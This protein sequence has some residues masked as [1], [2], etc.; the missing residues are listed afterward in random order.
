[1]PSTGASLTGAAICSSNSL[2]RRLAWS[3][4]IARPPSQAAARPTEV[5]SAR[6]AASRRPGSDL[7]DRWRRQS[8]RRLRVAHGHAQS[9]DSATVEAARKSERRHLTQAP[10]QARSVANFLGKGQRLAIV[11]GS[12][13]ELAAQICNQSESGHDG[14][15]GGTIGGIA[16]Q[17]EALVEAR[18]GGIEVFAQRGGIAKHVQ[19]AADILATSQTAVYLQGLGSEDLGLCRAALQGGERAEN[20]PRRGD[21]PF[22]GLLLKNL[23]RF[24]QRNLRGCIVAGG[25]LGHAAHAKS[26]RQL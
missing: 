5:M 7:F 21:A 9:G 2:P 20:F 3:T 11:V 18:S 16:T 26:H 10:H 1:M 22:V 12:H 8:K 15:G 6:S 19:C 17:R 4:V 14:C 25:D 24:G 23:Q 13:R